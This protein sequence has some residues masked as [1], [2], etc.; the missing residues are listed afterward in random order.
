MKVLHEQVD[1]SYTETAVGPSAQ[2]YLLLLVQQSIP[3]FPYLSNRSP[4]IH[5]IRG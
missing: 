4:N 5:G 3:M 1:L 2:C